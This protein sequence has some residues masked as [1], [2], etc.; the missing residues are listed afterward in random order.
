[1]KCL[2]HF[3][4]QLA[5]YQFRKEAEYWWEMVKTCEGE[6]VLTWVE[7]KNLIAKYYPKDVKWAK[8]QKFTRFKQGR[9]MSMMECAAKFNKLS[10]FTPVYMTTDEMRMERFE[11][12]L[13]G[14]LKEAV[15]SH[16]YANFHANFQEMYQKAAKIAQVVDE[17]EATKREEV[18]PQRKFDLG[19]FNP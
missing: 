10:H 12:G 8:K 17:N 16:F 2:E 3:K 15:A 7:F 18:Q 9:T 6:E 1:M 11:L 19:N 4:V 13:K 5:T 14:K